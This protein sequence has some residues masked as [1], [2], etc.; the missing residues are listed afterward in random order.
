[1]DH[2][3]FRRI[4]KT[5]VNEFVSSIKQIFMKYELDILYKYFLSLKSWKNLLLYSFLFFFDILSFLFYNKKKIK[6]WKCRQIF[7]WFLRE[8]LKKA[9]KIVTFQKWFLNDYNFSCTNFDI[10]VNF[11]LS[12]I[13]L[14]FYSDQFFA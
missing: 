10:Y 11:R 1:M 8:N 12:E 4:W 3:G 14:N 7:Y 13:N 6:I 9:L 5:V 2:V